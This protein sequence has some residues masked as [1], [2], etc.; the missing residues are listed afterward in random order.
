VN[1][2]SLLDKR[3]V[4]SA[5][6]Y[7]TT[8]AI[9]LQY[10]TL[11]FNVILLFNFHVFWGF[12]DK[13]QPRHLHYCLLISNGIYDWRNCFQIWRVAAN[14]LHKQSRTANKG[15]SSSLELG[16][17]IINPNRKNLRRLR[18]LSKGLGVGLILWNEGKQ[19]QRGSG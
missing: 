12:R 3:G 5:T 9:W 7:I 14:I 13:M 17:M 2:Y 10:N 19:W 11:L 8:V 6:G 1:L 16:H 4:N 15:L 18:K